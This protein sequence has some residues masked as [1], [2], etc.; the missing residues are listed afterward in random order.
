MKRRSIGLTADEKQA[1]EEVRD[2]D[3]RAYLR[4]RAAALLKIHAGDSAHAVAQRGLLKK[5]DPDTIYAWI[6]RYEQEGLGGLQQ[7]ARRKRKL[8]P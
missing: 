6:E 3:R 8:P 5:R 7:R 2:H 1:L 4:E